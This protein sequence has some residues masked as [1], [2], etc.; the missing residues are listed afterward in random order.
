MPN[1][2]MQ[3]FIQSFERMYEIRSI[4]L[5]NGETI[6]IKDCRV[7]IMVNRDNTA[8]VTIVALKGINNE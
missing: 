8:T 7:D 2:K 5:D 6:F 1:V 3:C 4:N